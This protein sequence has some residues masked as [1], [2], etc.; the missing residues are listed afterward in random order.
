MGCFVT[1]DITSLMYYLITL[2]HDIK[3]RVAS[4][5]INQGSYL[6]VLQLADIADFKLGGPFVKTL[7]IRS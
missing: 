1:A 2:A 7:K 6:V 3:S 4:C 5:G